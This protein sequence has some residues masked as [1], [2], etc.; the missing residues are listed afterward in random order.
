MTVRHIALLYTDTTLYG[1]SLYGENKY[2]S[3]YLSGY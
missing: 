2:L 1:H 3:K